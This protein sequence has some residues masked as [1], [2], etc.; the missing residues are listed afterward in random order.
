MRKDREGPVERRALPGVLL[1]PSSLIRGS[2][3]LLMDGPSVPPTAPHWREE[4][5]FQ[6]PLIRRALARRRRI[7]PLLAASLVV[8]AALVALLYWARP[9]PHPYF[10]PLWI[11]QYQ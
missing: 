8:I 1:L 4:K 7:F 5:R 3:E 9:I 11:T 6:A 2:G 10:V